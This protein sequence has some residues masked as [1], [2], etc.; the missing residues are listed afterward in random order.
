MSPVARYPTA[1]HA[2]GDIILIGGQVVSQDEASRLRR[3]HA[4]QA[5][6]CSGEAADFHH[7]AVRDL[8]AAL[9]AAHDWQRAGGRI[10][11]ERAA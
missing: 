2:G 1:W 4:A 8:L 11:Q 5:E 9:A 7:R 3:F 10:T 6:A